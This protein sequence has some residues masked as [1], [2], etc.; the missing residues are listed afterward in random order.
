MATTVPTASTEHQHPR[1]GAHDDHHGPSLIM[2]FVIFGALMVLTVA[3][4][5]TGKMHMGD[6]ALPV[7]LLIATT[8]AGLVVAFF[9]H[10]AYTRGAPLVSFTISV[11]FVLTLI[12]GVFGDVVFRYPLARPD[13][14]LQIHAPPIGYSMGDGPDGHEHGKVPMGNPKVPVMP[15][16]QGQTPTP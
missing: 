8:K 12:A 3:T 14:L 16:Q 9:M 11:F 1:K 5:V 10:L 4:Y 6:A 13:K 7:A 15:A 2:Y